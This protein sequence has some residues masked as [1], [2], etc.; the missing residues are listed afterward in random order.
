MI[1]LVDRM[2]TK[3]HRRMDS[4]RKFVFN[5][6]SENLKD[7]IEKLM[8]AQKQAAENFQ[9]STLRRRMERKQETAEQ[10]RRAADSKETRVGILWEEQIATLLALVGHDALQG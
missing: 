5:A 8:G 10:N 3:Q 4:M 2:R 9:K 1:L 7:G 6:A